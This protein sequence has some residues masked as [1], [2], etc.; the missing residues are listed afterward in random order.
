M[1]I[2]GLDLGYGHNKCCYGEDGKIKNL[3]KI[4]S[5]LANVE[6]HELANDKRIVE[7]ENEHYYVG[8][9]ALAV[10]SNQILDINSYAKLEFAAPIFIY[11]VCKDLDINP[12]RLVLGLSI[13]QIANSGYFK[14]RIE[15]FL[16]SNG[17]ECEI[18]LVPQGMIAKLAIDKYGFNF[19]TETTEFESLRNYVGVDIGFNTLD[20]FQVTNGKTSSNLVR[21]IEERGIQVIV[22]RL[23]TDIKNR[24]GVN[25]TV[26]EGKEVLDNG[27]LRRRGKNIDFSEEINKQVKVYAEELSVLI[28]NEF[29]EVLNKSEALVLFGGGSYSL[30]SLE[31]SFV[32]IPAQKAEFY[33]VIGFYLFGDR[34]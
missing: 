2:L 26:S 14:E 18:L 5:V 20:I 28:E 25:L 10:A 24:L 3:F 11:K 4:P 16:V 6:K 23:L 22:H 1:K 31:S 17:I 21:G 8:D 33:N 9:D 32:K 7:F 29:G 13:A 27:F 34:K 12:D 30:K 15:K 19:P